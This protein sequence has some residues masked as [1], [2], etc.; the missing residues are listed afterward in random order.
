MY[1][2][3]LFA[4]LII[5]LGILVY[6]VQGGTASAYHPLTYYLAFHGLVFV[7]RPILA[8]YLEFDLIYRLYHFRPSIETKSI[9]LISATV[10]LVAFTV[11]VMRVARQK[12]RLGRIAAQQDGGRERMVAT[13]F[14][15]NRLALPLLLT[16][17]L[18]G[19]IAIY[20]Q[21]S[22]LVNML[23]GVNNQV[24]DAATGVTY[25]VG[26]VGYLTDAP[27]ML[28]PLAVLIAWQY[29]FRFVA[30]L[31]FLAY[32]STRL[33]VGWGRWTFI[34]ASAS[35]ALVWLY[36]RG[37]RWPRPR[38]AIGGALMLAAFTVAGHQREFFRNLVSAER[39]ERAPAEDL[40][41]LEGMDYANLEYLEYVVHVVPERTGTHG[42]FL[43]NLQVFTEP[44]PRALW[45]DKPLGPP[46]KLYNLFDYGTPV[47]LTYS[48]AGEGWQQ[49]GY[50]G[51]ILWCGLFGYGFG[52]FYRWF[53]RSRQSAFQVALFVMVIPLSI[54]FF[55]DGI[56][57]SILRFLL[58]V[59]L[60]IGI[61][62]LFAA[63][64]EGTFDRH[65]FRARQRRPAPPPRPI[66][67]AAVN[68]PSR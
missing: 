1:E 31:P 53:M 61:W 22:G 64:R 15:D 18:C 36:S 7:F 45:P 12:P 11:P 20:A 40:K 5:W 47:G 34:M 19:P 49:A 59:L 21:Y 29:R 43:S 50:L 38:L 44:V 65:R 58:F 33:L 37:L 48:V 30:L 14:P 28:L 32:A 9:A 6:Y 46:I 4:G 26:Q 17:A 25:N 41:P 52:R 57:L 54:Q 39:V 3:L 66:A 35:L 56:L 62:W 23:A 60:P 10:G 24:W 68:G 63:I 67:A 51:V 55:R 27:N 13:R 2:F 8:H 16:A 42:W